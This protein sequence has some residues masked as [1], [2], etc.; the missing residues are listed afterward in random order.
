MPLMTVRFKSMVGRSL[1]NSIDSILRMHSKLGYEIIL[2]GI[3]NMY[4]PERY[5]IAK[6]PV[7]FLTKTNSYNSL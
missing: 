7:S 3:D 1:S 5:K 6:K 2:V 4:F